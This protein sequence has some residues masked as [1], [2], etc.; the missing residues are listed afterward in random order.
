MIFSMLGISVSISLGAYVIA[1]AIRA[2]G[3]KIAAAIKGAK[4]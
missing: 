3:D 1:L 4:P 2:A